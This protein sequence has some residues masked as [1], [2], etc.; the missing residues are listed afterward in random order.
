MAPEVQLAFIFHP[1][2]LQKSQFC[3]MQP[4]LQLTDNIV[5]FHT[6]S[7]TMLVS[8]MQLVLVCQNGKSGLIT[9]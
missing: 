4:T 6:L 8:L 3:F 1:Q 5:F 7:V 9:C 2:T